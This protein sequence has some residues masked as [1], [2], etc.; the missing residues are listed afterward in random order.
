VLQPMPARASDPL[1]ERTP[2]QERRASPARA[3]RHG[4]RPARSNGTETCADLISRSAPGRS[5]GGRIC[6]AGCP[7]RKTWPSIAVGRTPSGLPSWTRP[8]RPLPR[9]RP[10]AGWGDGDTA[11]A[12]AG[13]GYRAGLVYG[14]RSAASCRFP[15]RK[16]EASR[17]FPP[18]P[19]LGQPTETP[20]QWTD[21]F[22]WSASARDLSTGSSADLVV[23]LIP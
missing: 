14:E 21:T 6:T 17:Q 10:A 9:P 16:P 22:L 5:P 4:K 8:K 20:A 15:Q 13:A 23:S 18:A 1:T 19:A 2:G 3:T 11:S 12:G 7:S